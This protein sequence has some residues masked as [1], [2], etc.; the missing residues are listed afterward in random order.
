M[1]IYGIDFNTKSTNYKNESVFNYNIEELI[2]KAINMFEWVNLPKEIDERYLEIMLMTR[3]YVC[4]FKDE[5][6]DKFLCLDCT[7]G[8][9][10]NVYNIPTEYHII[11]ANGYRAERD[12]SN[13]VVIFNNYLH[14]SIM[15]KVEYNA[16]RISNIDRTI[17][18]NINQLKR[19]Y[20]FLV[21][22]N[23]VASVK[24]FFKL[25]KDNEECIIGADTLDLDS[26]S[27]ENT[28]TPNN[29]L[30]LYT[31]KKKYYNEALSSLG[32]NNFSDDKKERL[33]AGE[34]TSNDEDI[35]LTRA[36]YLNARKQACK[37]INEM[38]G[39]NIDV[40]F[41]D[42]KSIDLSGEYIDET[43]VESSDFFE[44]KETGD[45]E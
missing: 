3:G 25:I 40:K 4:F 33:L 16:K 42:I 36:S 37:Q 27:K 12:I 30:E 28:I 20:I 8:G 23:K 2:N 15:D 10:L 22:E 1:Q 38:F 7:I 45:N 6:L 34:I 19:P 29:T 31:L 26:M 14:T 18:V 43:I 44:D 41:R 32:I 5:E 17:E 35:K 9:K 39:L 21:P 11:T 24:T 13:S